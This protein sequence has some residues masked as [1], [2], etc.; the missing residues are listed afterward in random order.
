[1]YLFNGTCPSN[2]KIAKSFRILIESKLGCYY[3]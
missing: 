2:C 1:M 3:G